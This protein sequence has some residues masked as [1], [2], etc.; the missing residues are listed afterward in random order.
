MPIAKEG[1]NFTPVPAGTHQARCFGVIG[2]GTQ[3]SEM[4][5]D[6]YKVLVMWETPHERITL[7]KEDRPMTISKEYTLSLN[8]KATLRKHLE[9]WRGRAFT[10]EELAG[11]DV[12]AVIGAPCLISVVHQTSS[13][14]GTYAKIE[15]IS[16]IPKGMTV[17]EVF[18]ATTKF[19]IEDGE[20]EVFKKL[21]E[22]IQK[23]IRASE[24][25][26]PSR[27]TAPVE[28]GPSEADQEVPF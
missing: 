27:P 14:G 22:W 24:E 7:D 8:K 28:D 2:L 13:N 4:F 17:P 6:A 18:H 5:A 11:F 9:T 3:H 21:P 23:K 16:A 12:A 25:W 15:G 1:G 26:A 19:E 10:A 20:S